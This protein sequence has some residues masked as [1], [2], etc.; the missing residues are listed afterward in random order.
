MI[1]CSSYYKI[2]TSF[3]LYSFSI[4]GC[5]FLY[6]YI[7]LF[8][9]FNFNSLI[10]CLFL[11]IPF[12]IKIPSFP[13]FHWLPEVHCEVNTSIS[14][15]LA[16]LLSKLGVYGILRFIFNC[17][18]LFIYFISCFVICFSL[19]G[20]FIVLGCSSRCFDIKK[21]IGFSSILHLNFILVIIFLINYL[22]LLFTW[23]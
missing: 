19:L 4:I 10:L 23:I 6:I 16:G 9:I 21:I 22:S 12:F 15:F 1:F 8:I 13:F 18:F 3:Y 11:L 17:I 14:L 20:I 2:R 7:N 5:L